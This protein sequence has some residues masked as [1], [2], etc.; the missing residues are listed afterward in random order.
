MKKN[1]KEKAADKPFVTAIILGA[2]K[3]R[4]FGSEIPKQFLRIKGESLF[5]HAAWHFINSDLVDEVILTVPQGQ[6]SRIDMEISDSFPH[7]KNVRIRVTEG[8]KTRAESVFKAVSLIK[9]DQGYVII[10]DAARPFVPEKLISGVIKQALKY[11]GAIPVL[12]VSETVKLISETKRG[13][14]IS[15]IDRKNLFLSQTPQAFKTALL[16]SAFS[17]IKKEDFPSISDD[18]M[19]AEM[20][21]ADIAVVKGSPANKKITWNEDLE[22]PSRET[23]TGIGFDVHPFI[24][25]KP[26][27]LGGIKIPFD[28]GLKGHSDGDCLIHAISDA[29]LGAC[30]LPD[31]GTL[32]PSTDQKLKN[33]RSTLI[34]KKVILKIRHTG[35]FPVQIDSI[36]ICDAPPLSQWT[37]KMKESLSKISDI[38]V[39]NISIKTRHCEGYSI[40]GKIEGIIAHAAAKVMRID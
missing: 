5:V 15:T 31:I 6:K 32:F 40:F 2:G 35:F 25:G 20:M 33:I 17:K 13:R 4:R 30:G 38:P 36:V 29:F 19:L 11:D 16:K 10:H 24:R 27:F 22:F 12:P 23:R 39:K 7:K 3:G 1:L 26:L 34:I 18:S 28:S 21:E 9:N 37:D 14:Q 8:G